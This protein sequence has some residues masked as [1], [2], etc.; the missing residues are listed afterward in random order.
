MARTS[1]RCMA[2]DRGVTTVIPSRILHGVLGIAR[3]TVVL[4]GTHERSW[5]SVTPAQMEMTSLP[6]RAE[7]M[8]SSERMERAT[9]GFELGGSASLPEQILASR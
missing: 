8:P 9:W 1:A 3:T 2:L 7:A 5:A 4:S 6:S